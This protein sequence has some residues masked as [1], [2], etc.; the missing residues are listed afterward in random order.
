MP[1]Q[2]DGIE[3]LLRK[4]R[5]I[6]ADDMG[7]GKTVQVIG[8]LNSNEALRRVL[9]VCPK[10]LI[11]TWLRELQTWLVR[12]LVVANLESGRKEAEADGADVVIINYDMVAKRRELLDSL[13][14]DG[15]PWDAVVCDEAH[16][17]KNPSAQ[18][19]MAILGDTVYAR[20][21]T[22]RPIRTD[23]L[24]LLTGTPLLNHPVELF[25]LLKACDPRAEMVPNAL[26]LA[27]FQ[28][29]YCAPRQTRWG[30]DYSG[31]SNLHELKSLIS[32]GELMLRRTKE[33]VLTELPDKVRTIVDFKDATA[34]KTEKELVIKER[35]LGGEGGAGNGELANGGFSWDVPFS[36]G[37]DLG[38]KALTKIRHATSLLKVPSAIER[39]NAILEAQQK[40]VVWAHHKNVIDELMKGFPDS[41]V[42]VTG[43][44][45]TAERGAHVQRFQTDSS[46]R[47]FIGSIRAAGQGLTLTAASRVVFVEL[48]WSPQIMRQAED[49]CHRIGQRSCVHVEYLCIKGTIDEHMVSMLHR[50]HGTIERV[51][52]TPAPKPRPRPLPPPRAPAELEAHLGDVQERLTHAQ[53]AHRA[54]REEREA[55]QATQVRAQVRAQLAAAERQQSEERSQHLK[56]QTQRMRE[57][58]ERLRQAMEENMKKEALAA[59]EDAANRRKLQS[60]DAKLANSRAQLVQVERRVQAASE[61]EVL[62]KKEL[63]L[64]Q[65]HDEQLVGQSS[66][67]GQGVAP[68]SSYASAVEKDDDFGEDHT[69]VDD[70]H[71]DQPENG[72][73][74]PVRP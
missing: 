70:E 64:S 53:R 54:M 41:S 50:K 34:V 45:P 31:V 67:R 23:R 73:R 17:L 58:Y 21:R 3:M 20:P 74:G 36:M 46:V 15:R 57:E 26:T 62:L 52:E 9:I 16:Y 30:M 1:F 49:R 13:P 71:H 48:D 69:F 33:E 5:I 43:S 68:A 44:T 63:E 12:D 18:R 39:I 38:F 11:D 4:E 40:V 6:L 27:A 14:G 60:S 7:L 47:V 37:S 32:S 65:A 55:A 59:E 24:W 66:T 19:T 56:A 61:A 25:P 8:A 10:S 42:A 51:L 22:Q 2:N 29:R 35:S 72:G 28:K